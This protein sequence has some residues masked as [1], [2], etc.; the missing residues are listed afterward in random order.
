MDHAGVES[1]PSPVA[2]FYNIADDPMCVELRIELA[3]GGVDEA[4]DGEPR[5]HVPVAAPEPAPCPAAL[6]FEEREGRRHCPTVRF[7][8]CRP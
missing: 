3:R 1:S 7:G 5:R 4:G 6:V 8:K 2:S